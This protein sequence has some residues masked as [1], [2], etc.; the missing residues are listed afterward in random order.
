M[1]KLTL[2][3]MLAMLAGCEK[4]TFQEYYSCEQTYKAAVAASQQAY[5]DRKITLTTMTRQVELA[6]EEYEKCLKEAE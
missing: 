2:I 3:I 6:G 4:V 1:K 5:K